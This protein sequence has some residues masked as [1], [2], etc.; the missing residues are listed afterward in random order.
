MPPERRRKQ[1]LRFVE[2]LPESLEELVLRA[3]ESHIYTM[4]DVLFERRR[5][6]G[7]GKLKT[8]TLHFQKDFTLEQIATNE[9]GLRCKSEGKKLGNLLMRHRVEWLND[10]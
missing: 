8:V 4:M 1:N 9:E 2:S 7:L 10:W 6:G 5:Q 3:C